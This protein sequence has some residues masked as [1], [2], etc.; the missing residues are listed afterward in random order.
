MDIMGRRRRYVAGIDGGGTKTACMIAD[1]KGNLLAYGVAEGSN[2]QICGFS[3]AMENVCQSLDIACQ[4]AGIAREELEFIYLGLAGADTES[5]MRSLEKHLT[6]RL[7]GTP[8]RVVNDVWIVFACAAEKKWGAVSICGTGNNM[9]VK[10]RQ[11]EIYSVRALR[12]ML[13]NYGGGEH[14][15]EI[16]LHHAFRSEEH[17]GPYTNLEHF[18]PA[19]CECENME[20]LAYRIYESNY[21]YHRRFNIPKLVFELAWEGDE[22][23]RKIIA[24]MGRKIGTMLGSLIS[25]AGLKNENVPVVLAGSQYAKDEHQ[26]LLKPLEQELHKYVPNADLQLIRCPPALGAV[27][28]AMEQR[29]MELSSEQKEFMQKSAEK[30]LL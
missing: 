18:L 22:V 3:R 7:R 20:E 12:Y 9:A 30:M 27:F 2:H 4:Q 26:L 13:G 28:N 5:D 14:L 17:T 29:N 10:D 19:Y 15:A 16:A 24:D 25:H 8:Y 23:C 21:S 1:E 6:A 11:G